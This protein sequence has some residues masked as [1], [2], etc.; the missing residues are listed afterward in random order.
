MQKAIA[1]LFLVAALAGCSPESPFGFRLP[2]GDPAAGRQ[3]F[4]DLRCNSCHE[5]RGVAIEYREGLAHVPLGGQTTRVKTYGELVTSIINP[6]HRIAPPNRDAVLPGG[7]SIMSAAYLNEVT[8]VQ[9]LVD[10]VA[11]LQPTY[12]V[13]QPP[14][15]ARWYIYP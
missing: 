13:V 1:A 3:A 4:L 7:Q 8:T 14:I 15:P 9:Q 12:E 6:S 2:D 5:V 10:L 11:F